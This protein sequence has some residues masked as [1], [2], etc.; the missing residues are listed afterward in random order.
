MR[1]EIE[2]TE[3]VL[4]EEILYV[5]FRRK[6]LIAALLLIAGGIFAY[7]VLTE[8]DVYRGEAIVMIRRLPLGYQMPAESRAVLLRAEVVN[9]EIEI[10]TSPAVAEVVVTRLGLDEGKDRARAIHNV[11]K[12]IKAEAEPESNIIKISC[13]NMDPVR[14]AEVTNAALDAYLSVRAGVALDYDAVDYLDVQARRVRVAIDSIGAEIT[15]YG[16]EEGQL[17]RGR[18]GEQ[19]MG[20]INGYTGDLMDLDSSIYSKEEKIAATEEWLASDGDITHAPNGDIYDMATVRQSKLIHLDLKSKLA[21]ARARYAPEHPEVRR[22]ERELSSVA[23]M[24]RTEIE[25]SLLRQKVRL[26]E[27]R[28]ERRATARILDELEAQN[29][30]LSDDEMQIRMLEHELSIRADLYSVLVGRREQ[31]K[32]TAAT[33]PS[34]LNVGVVSRAAVPVEPHKAGINMKSV[35]AF[36]TF[37]FGLAFVFAVERMD[38]SLVRRPD[39][40]RE[41][42]LKVLAIVR[43]RARS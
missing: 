14:A 39:V 15:R 36:F 38:Q 28:A 32:I 26:D 17:A 7:G 40:E 42:G 8:V 5:V 41:L 43:H 10:I 37:L 20:L 13:S 18:K 27:W 31:F 24:V 3:A 33:D 19:H 25:Q 30:K 35:F 34:L 16:A 2:Q 21:E 9:S 22:L 23:Q 12:Q 29:P 1:R 6:L 4:L 11:N